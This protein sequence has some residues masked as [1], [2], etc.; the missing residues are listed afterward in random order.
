[1]R[2]KYFSKRQPAFDGA[3]NLFAA[4]TP[5]FGANKIQDKIKYR[6]EASGKETEYDVTIKRANENV[7]L[8]IATLFNYMRNGGCSMNMP[9]S[10][11]QAIDVALRGNLSD[12]L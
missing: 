11:I 10:T 9:L 1:M 12:H 5:L 4:K 3:K 7:E 6:K 8:T 2:R